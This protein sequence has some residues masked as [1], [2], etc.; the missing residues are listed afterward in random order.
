MNSANTRVVVGKCEVYNAL[1]A[2][3]Q[4]LSDFL[5]LNISP[6]LA[7]FFLAFA[8]FDLLESRYAVFM[9]CPPTGPDRIHDDCEKH[10]N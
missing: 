6:L 5:S 8:L 1:Q 10:I 2:V 9:R 4:V 3:H 7:P